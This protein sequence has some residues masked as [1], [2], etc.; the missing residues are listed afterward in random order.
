MGFGFGGGASDPFFVDFPKGENGT[1]LAAG[2]GCSIGFGGASALAV[3]AGTISA[4]GIEAN[5]MVMTDAG[6][7]VVAC[8]K[9]AHTASPLSEAWRRIDTKI[10]APA[11]FS[12]AERCRRMSPT[13]SSIRLPRLIDHSKLF[14]AGAIHDFQHRHHPPVGNG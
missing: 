2:F 12:S 1:I 7:G 13:L 10:A 4:R 8:R 3:T 5:R 14:H 6:C 9:A 11:P